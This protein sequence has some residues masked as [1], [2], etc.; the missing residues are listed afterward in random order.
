MCQEIGHTLG[1]DHQDENFD[2][3]PLGTC[4]DYSSDPVPNQ[5]PNQHDYDQLDFI[6]AHLD[7]LTSIRLSLRGAL[8]FGEFPNRSDWGRL[9]K[10][11][12]RVALFE[13]DL[14]GGHKMFTHVIWDQK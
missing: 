11:N 8:A 14:G 12:G 5:H 3:P 6:Y 1:L 9:L 7:E 10:D 13:R 4:M 2:N